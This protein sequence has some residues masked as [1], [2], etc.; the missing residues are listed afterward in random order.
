MTIKRH[1]LF[2]ASLFLTLTIQAQKLTV[3]S[4][5][6]AV[7]D[8]SASM[9]DNRRLDYNQIP[10]ALVKVQLPLSGAVFEGNVIQPVE[11]K[12][13]EYWVYMTKGSKELHIKH[14]NYQTLVVNFP[15]YG[16]KSLQSLT[17]Y[18]F[19]LLL[20]QASNPVQSQK[21]IIDYSP[22]D[23]I[24]V[25]DS[26][27]HQGNGHLELELPVGTH[28]YQLVAMGYEMEEGAVKLKASSPS[29]IKLIATKQQIKTAEEREVAENGNK[30]S[31]NRINTS[32]T[33]LTNP[34]ETIENIP[35]GATKE[36]KTG[37]S[38]K[39]NGYRVQVFAGG[40][41][42]E[43]HEQA[44]SIGNQIK[45]SYPN[46]PVYVHFYSPRWTCRVGNYRTY[47]EAHKMMLSLQE[48]GFT[49]ALLVKGRITVYE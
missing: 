47:D 2:V 3:E 21:L 40:N 26:K 46:I 15:D 8:Q 23:A 37:S 14:P 16:I 18:N 4:L 12:T 31:L 6:V 1:I 5:E 10:C 17:T 41:L 25:V 32:T 7:G 44:E 33:T 24:V 48:M 45:K 42:K 9:L 30:D 39:V 28:N 36:N 27:P 43:D 49:K 35:V 13:N 38:K 19:T 20:P 22:S 29:N 11:Y 34:E